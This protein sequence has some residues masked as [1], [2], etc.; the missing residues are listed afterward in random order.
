MGEAFFVFQR[1]LLR[2][3]LLTATTGRST[4]VT[5]DPFFVNPAGA[6]SGPADAERNR[7]K[8][9]EV[10]ERNVPSTKYFVS[11]HVDNFVLCFQ[12]GP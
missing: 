9:Q 11:I 1:F 10:A 8:G 4:T 3:S 12:H 2:T 7:E 5:G 6:P